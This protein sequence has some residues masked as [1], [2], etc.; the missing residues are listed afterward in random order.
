MV[1]G[2]FLGGNYVRRVITLH[3]ADTFMG[4]ILMFRCHFTRSGHVAMGENIDSVTLDDAIAVGR[5]MLAERAA[6][7]DLDGIEIWDRAAFLYASDL[8]KARLHRISAEMF[9]G[10]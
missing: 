8:P 2:Q 9:R 3:V 10:R 6:A 4:V 5:Q 1:V 7:D